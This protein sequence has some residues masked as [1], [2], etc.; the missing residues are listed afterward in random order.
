M[1]GNWNSFWEM[2]AADQ[3][4]GSRSRITNKK[5]RRG[6]KTLGL[7]QFRNVSWKSKEIWKRLQ[8]TLIVFAAQRSL[9]EVVKW[10]KVTQSCP[11]LCNPMDCSLPISSLHGI[12]QARTREWVAIPFSR[13]SSQPRDWTRSPALQ[14]LWHY[15]QILYI[16]SHQ[17]N[18]KKG[19]WWYMNIWLFL[20]LLFNSKVMSESLQPHGLQCQASLSFTISLSLHKL[21]S[22]ESVMPSNCVILCCPLLL[23]S[24][25]A[26]IG[27]FSSELA[28]H[29]R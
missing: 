13:G 14:G 16:L 5:R 3:T 9:K 12:L 7:N 17:R 26:S 15:R 29:I 6:G 22:F 19:W 1:K 4:W 2:R 24:I 28:L 20:L 18:P 23:S 10:V 8:Y 25:F 11:T 21:I 27:I